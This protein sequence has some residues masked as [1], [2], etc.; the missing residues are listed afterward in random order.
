[1]NQTVH[2]FSKTLHLD[3]LKEMLLH[4]IHN[5]S[6]NQVVQ[7]SF[8]LGDSTISETLHGK[9]SRITYTVSAFKCMLGTSGVHLSVVRCYQA[10]PIATSSTVIKIIIRVIH[11]I[12]NSIKGIC[13][14]MCE[15]QHFN[16]FNSG[17]LLVYWYIFTGEHD[18]EP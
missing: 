11:A 6:D 17:L 1:M 10:S 2:A 14:S 7:N 16:S 15:L 12:F 8:G 4:K 9:I 13:A 18:R 5:P 3:Q